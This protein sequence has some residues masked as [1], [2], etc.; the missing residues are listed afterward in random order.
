MTRFAPIQFLY[1]ATAI[2]LAVVSGSKAQPEN[3]PTY[4]GSVKS[5]LDQ[6]C[7][8]CHVAGGIAPFA[9][10]TAEEARRHANGIFYAV[11]VN[12]MPPFPPGEDSPAF[13][14]DR[15]LEAK[16]KETLLKWAEQG[17]PIGER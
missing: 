7:V 4:Y 1:A 11:R 6:H 13:I 2:I 10:T 14:N 15:R 5:I 9:L 16:T 8:E 12:R 17:A 3:L